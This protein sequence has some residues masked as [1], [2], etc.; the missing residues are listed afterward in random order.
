[1]L[2][3][4]GA[5]LLVLI[6]ASAAA[7]QSVEGSV[8]GGIGRWV[9]DNGSS[10][11]LVSAAGG[12]EWLVTPALGL[13]GEGGL[14]ASPRGDLAATL[15]IDARLHVGGSRPTATWVPYVFAGYSPLRFFEM[16][17][18]GLTYGAGVDHRLTPRR[19]LRFELRDIVRRGGSVT[20][21]YWT[22]RVGVTFR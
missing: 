16:S 8:T 11:A 3:R 13:A 12:G 4:L 19:A 1:M 14:L 5:G 6:F 10:G 18:Q 2:V 20:S 9:H 21:H 15:T 17:D 7:A 22:A